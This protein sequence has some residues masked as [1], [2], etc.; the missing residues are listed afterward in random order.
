MTHQPI[1]P[2]AITTQS[3]RSLITAS[4][5]LAASKKRVMHLKKGYFAGVS[6][7]T[8][9]GPNQRSSAANTPANARYRVGS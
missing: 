1:S 3:V 8:R 9:K 4:M 7:M 2:L 6:E 5:V